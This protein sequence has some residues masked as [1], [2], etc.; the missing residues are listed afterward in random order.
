MTVMMMVVFAITVMFCAMT[1]ENSH[2]AFNDRTPNGA[3]AMPA[4]RV[5]SLPVNKI[6]KISFGTTYDYTSYYYFKIKP[7]KTGYITFTNDYTH[8]YNVALCNSK[9]KVISKE[10]KS[11]DDFYSAGSQ[12][13]YQKVLHYGVK[14]GKTYYIRVKGASSYYE[15]YDQPYVGNI[16]W[17]NTK[18][19]AAKSGTKRTKAKKIKKGKTIKGL[20][21]AGDKKTKWY[22]FTTNKKKVT[23]IFKAPKTNGTLKVNLVY[24]ENVTKGKFITGNTGSANRS[25]SYSK[26]S[27][28]QLFGK[29]K[30]TAYIKITPDYKSSGY[31]TL[32][33]K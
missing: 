18:V 6:V 21:V 15:S 20:F 19:K 11:Y 33:W 26:P 10:D 3:V 2:A 22:K 12:Y 13:A 1:Q 9:K 4:S 14:K 31:Y 28:Q 8:G 32:K 27:L 16:L 30:Y 29:K 17:K 7:S 23:V 24:R 25:G 5:M